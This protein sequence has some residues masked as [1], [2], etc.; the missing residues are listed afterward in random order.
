MS[1]LR[2]IQSAAIDADTSILTILRQCQVL[3]ARL[4]N[5]DFK[6][7]VNS[8]LNG[9]RGEA[10]QDIT[11]IL[12]DYRIISVPSKGH[13]S[14]Y[15]GKQLRNADISLT[16]L[17]EEY[18]ELYRYHYATAPISTY[19]SLLE[20]EGDD[21]F[22]EP[23]S[24]EVVAYAADKMYQGMY[25]LSAWKVIPRP[26]VASLVEA[27][28]NRVLSFVLEIESEAPDA[29][30]APINSNPIPQDK[31][32]QVFNTFISGNVQ[33]VATGGN[34]I[35]Q[36]ATIEVIPQDFESLADYLR[37][38]HVEDTDITEL[39]TAINGDKADKNEST[40][41]GARVAS[42]MA[43]MMNK[44]AKGIWKIGTDTAVSVITKAIHSYYGL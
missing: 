12:P 10:D 16:C 31:V 3:A 25:C 37:Q 8:E 4:G 30:E 38:N 40:E 41:I 11:A 34:T 24:S 29:G 1:L 15:F 9:Y 32:T 33:N 39:K 44:S 18:R 6:K 23:W 42:W 17:P 19:V 43:S 20:G 21:N 28:R 13:F 14:G 2:D 7:W 36:N 5:E 27:V 22:Q 26:A 35:T